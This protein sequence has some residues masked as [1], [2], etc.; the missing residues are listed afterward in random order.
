VA[1]RVAGEARNKEADSAGLRFLSGVD[2]WLLLL[3]LDSDDPIDVMW[4]DGGMLYFWIR[5]DDLANR[6]FDK[7]WMTLQCY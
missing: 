2:Q 5:R 7:T 6:R 4:G 3:Q 1:A